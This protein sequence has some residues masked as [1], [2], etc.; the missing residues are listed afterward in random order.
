MFIF[1]GELY[2]QIDGVAMGSPLGPTFANIFLC[3][4]ERNWLDSCPSEFK[5]VVYR[6]YVDDTFVIFREKWQANRFLEY[7]N[8]KHRNIGFTMEAETEGKLAFLDLLIG[9]TGVN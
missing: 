8:S 7:L 6:R 3:F 4:H 2:K 5:P 1:N 9:K